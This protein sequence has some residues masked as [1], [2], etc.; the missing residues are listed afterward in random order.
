MGINTSAWKNWVGLLF[1][2]LV[3]FLIG[4]EPRQIGR[5]FV[6]RESEASDRQVRGE[7]GHDEHA[8]RDHQRNGQAAGHQVQKLPQSGGGQ[9]QAKTLLENQAGCRRQVGQPR[10]AVIGQQNEE[11]QEL[12]AVDELLADRKIPLFTGF[13]E[14]SLGR[15]LGL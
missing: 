8:A 10:C 3:R 12:D 6:E 9:L 5:E 1:F 4:I 11:D 15:F 2:R 13:F 14:P 7:A